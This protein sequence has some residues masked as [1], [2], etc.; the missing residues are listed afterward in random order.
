M[1]SG[2]TRTIVG[3]PG[4]EIFQNLAV[5]LI[6]NQT[7]C[8]VANGQKCVSIGYFQTPVTLLNRTR[9]ID[10][11]CLPELA[12]PLILGI[13][14]WRAMEIIPNLKNDVWHFS[15]SCTTQICSVVDSSSLSDA[16]RAA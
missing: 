14:F 3:K 16:D 9:L 13:D 4:M 2:A 1:D 7:L 12:H 11:L 6:K 8:T 5:K 10:I 15:D